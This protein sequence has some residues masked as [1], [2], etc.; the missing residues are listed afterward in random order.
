MMYLLIMKYPNC[1]R[2]TLL[3]QLYY[4]L[5]IIIIYCEDTVFL[6]SRRKDSLMLNLIINIFI[7]LLSMIDSDEFKELHFGF[8]F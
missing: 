7:L 1:S 2:L 5:I 6:I 4:Y 8:L 3:Y